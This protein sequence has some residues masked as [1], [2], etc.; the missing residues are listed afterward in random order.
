MQASTPDTCK[1]KKEKNKLQELL[2]AAV[3]TA[4]GRKANENTNQTDGGTDEPMRVEYVGAERSLS[5]LGPSLRI[6]P[7]SGKPLKL[8]R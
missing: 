1:R 5:T 3:C 8:E 4:C 7:R 6:I 2:L